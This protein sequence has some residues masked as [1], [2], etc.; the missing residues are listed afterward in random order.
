MDDKRRGEI[1]LKL[2]QHQLQKKGLPGD[3]FAR[4]LGNISKETDIHTDEL[5]EFYATL[6]P[7]FIRSTLGYKN[8]TL[9]TS[10]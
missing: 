9:E 7:D 5:R 8:V 2:I 6:L 10:D 4:D 1:A 3:S